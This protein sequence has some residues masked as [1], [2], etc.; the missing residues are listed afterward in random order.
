MGMFDTIILEI[1]C[2][3]CESIITD[4]QTKDMGRGLNFINF[5]DVPRNVRMYSWC[6]SCKTEV[7]I[8]KGK[9]SSDKEQKKEVVE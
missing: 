3:N 1:K 7:T 6:D 8:I 9:P 2:P 5:D 4:F